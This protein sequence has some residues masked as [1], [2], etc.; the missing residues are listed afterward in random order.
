[1]GDWE[2]MG[3]SDMW[4]RWNSKKKKKKPRI[5]INFAKVFPSQ[6]IVL[7]PRLIVQIG[8]IYKKNTGL[9]GRSAVG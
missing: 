6:R 2:S 5:I 7:V 8:L 9:Y 1:M 3:G 4:E